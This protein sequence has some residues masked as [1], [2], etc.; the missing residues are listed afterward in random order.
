[1]GKEQPI[2]VRNSTVLAPRPSEP[3]RTISLVNADTLFSAKHFDE[4]LQFAREWNQST[5]SSTSRTVHTAPP[6]D[7]RSFLRLA[8]QRMVRNGSSYPRT[9]GGMVHAGAIVS[10]YG[11]RDE[12]DP[13]DEEEVDE[14]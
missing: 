8:A 10:D 4:Y 7:E 9:A 5:D 3:N 12:H 6:M 14:F 11:A 1:M 2:C 13:D